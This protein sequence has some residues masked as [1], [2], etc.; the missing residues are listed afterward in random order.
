MGYTHYW[1]HKRRFTKA[2]WLDVKTDIAEIVAHAELDGVR[3]GSFGG[4]AAATVPTV[5]V[6]GG[7]EVIGFNGYGDEACETF[8]I[9]QNRRP[10]EEWEKNGTIGSD[11]CKTRQD[12]YDI[13]VTACLC[14]LE[15]AYPEKFNVDSDG[16]A[17]DWDA[18]LDLARRALPKLDNVLRMPRLLEW[19]DRFKRVY[20]YGGNH[21]IAETI[22]GELVV[23]DEKRM[24]IILQANHKDA[25]EWTR[26]WL[27]R[28]KKESSARL[29]SCP[30]KLARWNAR[31]TREFVD[32]ATLF[33]YYQPVAELA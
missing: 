22:T 29:P 32:G 5:D 2:E 8:A 10:L 1:T 9:Y 26:N 6:W 21:S 19:N 3:I 17:A 4:E 13:A 15:S 23:T 12:P 20:H 30:E 7:Q 33:D 31:K 16:S 18:G 28:I 11:F 27:E 24:Q 14:Y 25:A